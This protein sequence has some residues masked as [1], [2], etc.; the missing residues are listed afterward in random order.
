MPRV[1][2]VALATTGLLLTVAPLAG[3]R[4]QTTTPGVV[5]TIKVTLTDSSITIQKDRFSQHG[6]PY[7]PRGGVIHYAIVNRG[8][9]PYRFKVW[10]EVTAPIKPGGHGSVLVNWNYRGV[11]DY[12]T[13]YQGKPVGP[14]GRIVIF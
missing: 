12:S 6:V 2:A 9:R 8:K 10:D 4:S 14:K 11:F 5:Y 3:A 13:L 1:L 7:Y